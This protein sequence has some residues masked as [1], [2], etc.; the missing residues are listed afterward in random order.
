MAATEE[1]DFQTLCV[2]SSIRFMKAG[3]V[4]EVSKTMFGH[5]WAE[6]GCTHTKADICTERPSLG[7]FQ[8]SHS[9]VSH[10]CT[11]EQILCVR[12]RKAS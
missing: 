5:L 3:R 11:S 8:Q 7:N 2:S 10:R 1:V 4:R 9:W 12:S 6:G